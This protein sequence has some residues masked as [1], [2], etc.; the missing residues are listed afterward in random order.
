MAERRFLKNFLS[1]L[2]FNCK[3]N[4]GLSE[5]VDYEFLV[6]FVIQSE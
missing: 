3:G 4:L 2:D 5:V 1:F 6:G